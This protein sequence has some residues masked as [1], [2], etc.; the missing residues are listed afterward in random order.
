[1]TILAKWRIFPATSQEV[2][3]SPPGSRRGGF[4]IW[5]RAMDDPDDDLPRSYAAVIVN[6]DGEIEIDAEL[7]CRDR[8]AIVSGLRALA[9]EVA[10]QR[11]PAALTH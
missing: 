7:L 5:G 6:D 4:C 11:P 2:S 8:D 1:M 10:S 9:D 3:E